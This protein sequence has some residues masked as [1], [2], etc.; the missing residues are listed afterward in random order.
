MLYLV[1]KE[2]VNLYNKSKLNAARYFLAQSTEE[3]LIVRNRIIR[4]RSFRTEAAVN[5][6]NNPFSTGTKEVYVLE[7]I[8]EWADIVFPEDW[9]LYATPSGV[10]EL[11]KAILKESYA[12]PEATTYEQRRALLQQCKEDFFER[13]NLHV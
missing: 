2:V 3:G 12:S 4:L 6:F 7:K 11:A 5:L 1:H 13:N 9:D 10:K 8:C